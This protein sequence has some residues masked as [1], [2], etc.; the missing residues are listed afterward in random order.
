MS[1]ERIH[2]IAI[3]GSAMH[4]LAIA[5]K[6]KGYQVSGSDDQIFEPSR[7]RL[8][9]QQLLPKSE[10]WNPSL[11]DHSID[12]VILGMHAKKDN[13]ELLKAQ[14]LNIPIFSYPEF[15]YEESKTKRR[16]VIGGSHG[17]TSITSMVLHVLKDLDLSFDY[18]VGAKLEGFDTM[19]QLSD[20]PIIVIEGDEYLSSPIDRKPKFLWYKPEVAVL[21]GIAWDHINVFPTFEGYIEQFQKFVD[22][23]KEE[24]LLTY[25]SEDDN[26][27]KIAKAS[28]HVR[29]KPYTTPMHQIVDGKTLVSSPSGWIELDFFGKHNLQNMMAAL[30]VCLELGIDASE[31]YKSIKSFKGASKRLE[32]IA[33]SSQLTVYKDFAHSP[34]KLKATTQAVK[35]QY[36]DKTLVA[37]MELHTFSSLNKD[38]LAEYKGAMNAADEAYVYFNP[39]T[40]KHKG[41]EELSIDEVKSSFLPGNVMVYDNSKTLIKLLQEK[42]YDDH[43]L[44]LMTSGNFDGLNINEFAK[45]LTAN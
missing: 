12:K 9:A 26:L 40:I 43:V 3:G 29:L 35:S 38:F 8:E 18:L 25:Y 32:K 24:G 7:S 17:K 1:K 34:S 33:E 42:N 14:E 36:K 39:A 13:P 19:V 21:S 6:K 30:N 11:I 10:G 45:E 23:I 41:L 16:I 15:V 22:S 4:N 31:F 20:A 27:S 2:F 5:L 37:C 28:S 44:L